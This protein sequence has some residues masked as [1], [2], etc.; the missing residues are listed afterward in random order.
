MTKCTLIKDIKNIPV[1]TICGCNKL[2]QSFLNAACL[3]VV[4][5]DCTADYNTDTGTW[6]NDVCEIC[7]NKC[8]DICLLAKRKDL[9][10]VD[11]K[12]MCHYAYPFANDPWGF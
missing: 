12:I 4:C 3:R 7:P 2:R 10:E 11:N 6:I 1:C 9:D 5:D 8:D